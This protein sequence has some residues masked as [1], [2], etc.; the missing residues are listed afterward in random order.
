[1]FVIGVDEAGRG[2]V[3]GPLIICA[4]AIEGEKE[5][6]LKKEGVKDSKLLSGKERERIAKILAHHPHE[7]CEVPAEEITH[8]M[9]RNVSLNE[10][11]AEKIAAA[12]LT[13]SIRLAKGA[14]GFGGQAGEVISK[15]F[16]DSPDPIPKKFEVRIRK[17]LRGTPL[18]KTNIVSENKADFKYLC[19]GA[20]SILAKS[21]RERRVAD[22]AAEVG[23][24]FGT[25]Y[26]S[27]EK[28][29]EFLKKHYKDG[30]LQKYIR[31]GWATMKNIRTTELKLKEFF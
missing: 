1:M 6:E 22:I 23:E 14:G 8:Y 25:G 15:I 10:M 18:E 17:Y 7:I 24:D 4:Y 13:L 27:D 29:V 30:N 28:T 3:I 31:H 2:P 20:A 5:P 19:V 11:E 12:V 21:M 26:P 9:K 16:V